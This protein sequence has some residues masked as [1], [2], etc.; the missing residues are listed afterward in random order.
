MPNDLRVDSEATKTPA[1]KVLFRAVIVPGQEAVFGDS[2]KRWGE[3]W[4]VCGAS[5]IASVPKVNDRPNHKFLNEERIRK[6]NR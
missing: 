6:C 3:G 4:Q 2:S 1:Q 5:A